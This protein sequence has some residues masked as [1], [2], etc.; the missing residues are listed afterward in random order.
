MLEYV[1]SGSY[2]TWSVVA[3][4]ALIKKKSQHR[5]I[6]AA[7]AARY[8]RSVM[9]YRSPSGDMAIAMRNQ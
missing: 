3:G 9:L 1:L 8:S 6:L 7:R 4:N 2:P 5:H